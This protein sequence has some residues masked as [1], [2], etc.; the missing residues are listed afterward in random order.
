M[1]ATISGSG[2]GFSPNNVVDLLLDL[3]PEHLS[4]GQNDWEFLAS[5]F[6]QKLAAEQ[7]RDMNIENK[8]QRT[9]SKRLR[10]NR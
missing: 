9:Q 5:Q 1:P 10:T 7:K 3:V 2:S 6:N 8:L 4:I